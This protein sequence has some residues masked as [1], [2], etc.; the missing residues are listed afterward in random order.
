MISRIGHGAHVVALPA[1]KA[2]EV[3]AL[4]SPNSRFLA[5]G[6]AVEFGRKATATLSKRATGGSVAELP[7][8]PDQIAALA[9]SPD[10]RLLATAAGDGRVRVWQVETGRLISTSEDSKRAGV[11]D[12]A[13]SPDTR[14][15]AVATTLGTA[16]VLDAATGRRRAVFRGHQE[17][18]DPRVD[19][20]F[21]VDSVEFSPDGRTS[22]VPATMARCGFGR[23]QR[24]GAC[25]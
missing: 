2:Y 4:F 8:H 23:R 18:T 7:G 10:S 9:F 22:L 3:Q 25:S 5:L 16:E 12:V 6:P 1:I 24:V 15:V 13:F 21:P 14:L 11:V 19:N 20:R 17:A